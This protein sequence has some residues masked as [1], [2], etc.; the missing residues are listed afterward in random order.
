M[1]RMFHSRHTRL[2]WSKSHLSDEE[3]AELEDEEFF[4]IL[5]VKCILERAYIEVTPEE[6]AATQ[7][8]MT[9]NQRSKFQDVLGSHKILFDRKLGLFPDEKSKQNLI[10]GAM[11][12]HKKAYPVPLKRQLAVFKDELM[13]LVRKKYFGSLLQQVGLHILLS[14]RRKQMMIEI[15]RY[16]GYLS[17]VH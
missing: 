1:E 14:S 8:P 15:V 9:N 3:L 11:P 17:F 12:V 4:V 16:V 6:Y 7:N 13:Y 2:W 5:G 10:P